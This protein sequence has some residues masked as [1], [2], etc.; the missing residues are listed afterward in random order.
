M[1]SVSAAL[2]AAISDALDGH[3]FDAAPVTTDMIINH[4][5]GIS[6]EAIPLAQNNFRG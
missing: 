3:L 2:N 5:A 1:G 4:V 6:E